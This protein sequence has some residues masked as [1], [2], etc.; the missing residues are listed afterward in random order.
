[1][2]P[3][4]VTEAEAIGI[5]RNK[6]NSIANIYRQ[7]LLVR[8]GGIFGAISDNNLFFMHIQLVNLF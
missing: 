6:A 7:L 8:A 1:M 2:A 5:I 3:V 4:I